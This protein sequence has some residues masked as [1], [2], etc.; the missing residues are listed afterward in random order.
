MIP[1]QDGILDMDGIKGDLSDICSGRIE[2]KDAAEITLF[3]SVGYALEDLVA[4]DY[5]LKKSGAT[6][7]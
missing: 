4:G 3:K 6:Q 7:I 1:I 2:R 5:Y